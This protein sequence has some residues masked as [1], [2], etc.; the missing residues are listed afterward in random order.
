M[1]ERKESGLTPV[2]SLDPKE[3]QSTTMEMDGSGM[4]T[5]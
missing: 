3:E 2:I 5:T 1:F 4:T